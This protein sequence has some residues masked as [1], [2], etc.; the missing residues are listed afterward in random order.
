[1]NDKKLVDQ[2]ANGMFW[3]FIDYVGVKGIS[4]LTMLI[5][6]RIL[7][8]YD[9]GLIAITSVFITIGNILLESGLSTSLIRNK[10]NTEADYSTIFFINIIIS[11]FLYL[12]IYINR[13]NISLYFKR[14]E[15]AEI[16]IYYG[17]L[18]FSN[19][20]I[21]VQNAILIKESN[22]R[23]I[24]LINLPSTIIGCSIGLLT[25]YI[26]FEYWSIIGMQVST[27]I[28]YAALI[29]KKSFW[30][31][32]LIFSMDK[33]CY[34]FNFGYKLLISS[35]LNGITLNIYNL[36]LAKIGTINQV[37]AFERANNFTNYPLMILSQIFGKVSFPLMVNMREN[38]LGLKKIFLNLSVISFIL[39]TLIMIL[40][41][42]NS[43]FIIKYIFG[44]KWM[45][46][47]IYLKA[48]SISSLFYTV[49]ALN[50]NILKVNGKSNLIL[51][52]EI[53]LKICLIVNISL[54]FILNKNY[55]IYII[56][57]NSLLATLI[58]VYLGSKELEIEIYT[59]LKT[60][61][62]ILV[63]LFVAYIT[64]LITLDLCRIESKNMEL[65]YKN[66]LLMIIY[67]DLFMFHN[68]D[69]S[70]LIT[71]SISSYVRNIYNK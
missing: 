2:A 12:L 62:I 27:Q 71:N 52:S 35:I 50:I 38:S 42:I 66:L 9:F 7:T 8:P 44:V 22:F 64:T 51:M 10:N 39:T 18:Y 6:T 65:M 21:I 70:H 40:I 1:M 43:E 46:M 31:P 58:T 25:A 29:Y 60:Y 14:E 56:F 5:L 53:L 19:A 47:N 11:I 15:L 54:V 32:K 67:F 57:I 24:T 45:E 4:F 20:I 16:L 37:G 68:K 28:V 17:L 33:L 23:L 13:Q 41:N 3:V 69:I 34:H 26:G 63:Q 36:T 55:F 61:L 30:S 49:Q 48:I 59:Q